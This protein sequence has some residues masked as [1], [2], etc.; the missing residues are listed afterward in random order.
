VVAVLRGAEVDSTLPARAAHRGASVRRVPGRVAGL[1]SRLPLRLVIPVVLVVAGC[2]VASLGAQSNIGVWGLIQALPWPWFPCLGALVVSFLVE[3]FDQRRRN[4]LVLGVHLVGLVVLLHGAPGFLEAEPRFATAWLHAGFTDQILQHGTTRPEIDARFNWPGFFG[5][6]AAVTG[7]A[8]LD[9]PMSLVRWAPV[10]FVSLYL[11]PLYVIAK[12]LID[13]KLGIWLGLF[14]FVPVNWVGQDYF[15][16][17]ALGFLLYLAAIAIIV[18]MFR[19]G[20]R[21]R[22]GSRLSQWRDRPPL[23]GTPDIAVDGRLRVALIALLVATSGALA[24]SHQLSPLMLVFAT[25]AL[26]LVGRFRLLSFPVLAGILAA[27]WLSVGAT[28]YWTGHMQELFGP[29]GHVGQT[30]GAVQARSIGSPAHLLVTQLRLWFTVVVWTLMALSVLVLWERRKRVPVTL[31][32]LAIVPFAAAIQSYG[33]EGVLRIF[34]FSSPFACLVIAQGLASIDVP[35]TRIVI[36][37][38]LLGVMPVFLITRYGNEIFEQVLP[39]D[40]QAV[41]ALHR[42]APPG[43]NLISP[44]SQVPWRYADAADYHYERPYT[45]GLLAGDP[46]AVRRLVAQSQAGNPTYLIITR[47]QIDYAEQAGGAER[48]WFT[49]LLQPLLTPRRG[50]HLVFHNSTAWIYKFEEVTAWQPYG[51]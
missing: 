13:S 29:L 51:G 20:E 30:V 31:L 47:D 41:R 1:R 40:A 26:V 12:Q 2:V 22:W 19:Q 37:L 33:G 39:G 45:P 34:L 24:V 49:D 46:A 28:A 16:P 18:T 6:A 38:G 42:I 36:L 14:L 27:G 35:L 23:D 32:T 4:G 48:G 5:A 17:Q 15:A 25:A 8:G 50:Y 9:T 21:L 7:A 44:T 43:S 10:V 3:L 11:P